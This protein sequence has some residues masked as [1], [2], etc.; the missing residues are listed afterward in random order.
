[1][2]VR[3]RNPALPALGLAAAVTIAA[4]MALLP[5][6]RATDGAPARGA[7]RLDFE[8]GDLSQFDSAQRAGD[9][10]LRVVR[11]PRRQGRY[12]ARFEVRAGDTQAATTGIRAE[13]IA[14]RDGGRM[15][16]AGEERW[17]RWSTMFSRSYPL[18]E[19]WQT[20]VQWKNDGTGSPPLAMTVNGDE[21]L[22]SGGNQ[23]AFHEFWR[24]PIERHRWHDFVAHIRWSPNERRGFV[25]LWHNGRHVVPRTRTATLYRDDEDGQPI[26][27][28]LKIGLYRSSAI[29]STQVLYHDGLVVARTRRG[30]R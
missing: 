13:L 20:F 25:E 11:R 21:I 27:N 28:Y 14:E 18:S 1:V 29:R 30:L 15:V 8:T 16:S 6:L 23:N 9:D 3:T 7:H 24:A 17:Y 22:L 10:R 2:T 19:D 26:P 12:A 5:G 4:A